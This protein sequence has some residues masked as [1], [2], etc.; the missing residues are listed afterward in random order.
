[1]KMYDYEVEQ[2]FKISKG[3]GI[4]YTYNGGKYVSEKKDKRRV[5]V[6]VTSFIGVSPDAEHYYSTLN[7]Y[8]LGAKEVGEKG[9]C[10]SFTPNAP[11]ELK[12]FDIEITYISKKNLVKKGMFLGVEMSIKK[13]EQT[14][15]FDDLV[16]LKKR[17]IEELN[18]LFPK[19]DGWDW[20]LNELEEEK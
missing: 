16:L 13:G 17:T 15:R 1:M 7:I 6:K 5:I 3:M 18:R 9:N 14:P 20:D 11:E 12:G 8:S 10:I 4:K 19:E 2:P